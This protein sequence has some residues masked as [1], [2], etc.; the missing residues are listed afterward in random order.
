[1]ATAGKVVLRE[2]GKRGLGLVGKA[3][4]FNATGDCRVCCGCKAFTVVRTYLDWDVL[5]WDL[6]AFQGNHVGGAGGFWRIVG[7]TGCYVYFRGCVDEHGKLLNLQSSYHST[8]GYADFLELQIGCLEEDGFIHYQG[9]CQPL[10]WR[11]LYTC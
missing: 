8:N 9:T 2:G 3:G 10:D 1:M 4:V 11:Y 6:S 7:M 5:E